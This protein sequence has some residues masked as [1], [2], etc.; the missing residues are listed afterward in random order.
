MGKT[1]YPLFKQIDIFGISPLFTIRGRGT[2]QTQIGS[3]LT[4]ICVMLIIIY[5]SIFLNEMIYHKS[6]NIQ[7]TIYYDEIPSEIQL[8]KENFVFIFGLKTKDNINFIDESIY[9]VEGNQIKININDKNVYY[10]DNE[11]LNIIKCSEYKFEF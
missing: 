2:F 9:N 5:I 11:A 10:Y 1:Q 4:I 7:S 6:P 8:K 3:F